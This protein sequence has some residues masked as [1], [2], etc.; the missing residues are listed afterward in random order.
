M[1]KGWTDQGAPGGPAG[2]GAGAGAAPIPRLG[3]SLVMFEH[4]ANAMLLAGDDRVYVDCNR[5]LLLDHRG[6]S[7]H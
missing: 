1:P 5:A 6:T 7:G 2:G 3:D 4:T